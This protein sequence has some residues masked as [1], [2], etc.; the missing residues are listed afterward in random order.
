MEDIMTE[1]Q[2][3]IKVY[4]EN[5]RKIEVSKKQSDIELLESG[6]IK[7]RKTI[8]SKAVENK[9]IDNMP[10]KHTFEKRF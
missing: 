8:K 3:D 9:T 7:Q 6:F 1:K 5:V 4:D 2:E 10:K